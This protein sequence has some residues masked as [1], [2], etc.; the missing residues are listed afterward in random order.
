MLAAEAQRGGTIAIGQESEVPDFDETPW[1]DMQQEAPNELD[2][3]QRHG[4][5]SVIVLR[6]AP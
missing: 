2:G 3:I 5:D 4:L 1:Q 6:V